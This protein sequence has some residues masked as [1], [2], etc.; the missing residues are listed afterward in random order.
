MIEKQIFCAEDTYKLGFEMGQNAKPFEAYCL[1]GDLGAGKTV[2]VKGFAAGMGLHAEVTSPTF[3]IVNEYNGSV[4]LYHF[5]AY[6]IG[7]LWEMEDIGF[8]DYLFSPGVVIIEWAELIE[9]LIPENALWIYIDRNA[10]MGRI[11]G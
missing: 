7:S 8:D 2:F 11:L 3:N 9:S 5:D 10:D 1:C 4:P 6:R